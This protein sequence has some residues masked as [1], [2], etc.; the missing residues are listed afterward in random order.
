MTTDQPD[1]DPLAVWQ[2]QA[3]DG[4]P[5]LREISARAR[6]FEAQNRRRTS[7]FWIAAALYMAVSITEDFRGSK[8]TIWWIGAIRFGLFVSWV[9]YIPFLKGTS[10][11]S[12]RIVGA[13]PVLD[14]YRASLQRR[15]DY[16]RD[17]YRARLQ[18]GLLLAGFV[19]YSIFYPPLFLIFGVP[20]AVA[21][22]V[23]FKRWRIEISEIEQEIELLDRFQKE[24]Q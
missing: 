6:R 3:E 19:I 17:S 21:G 22:A 18:P 10:D 1:H 2:S 11:E 7:I 20:T 14:T 24:S 9:L 16:F 23:A 5:S 12:L 15:R 13:T 8:G 4:A